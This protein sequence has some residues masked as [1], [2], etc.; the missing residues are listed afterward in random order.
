MHARTVRGRLRLN[1][2][3]ERDA[4]SAPTH[5]HSRLQSAS[6]PRL[7]RLL[8]HQSAAGRRCCCSNRS[9]SLQY[10]HLTLPAYSFFSASAPSLVF[11]RRGGW[12]LGPL[13]GALPAAHHRSRLKGLS[14][15]L[16]CLPISSFRRSPLSAA[17]SPARRSPLSADLLLLLNPSPPH[18]CPS[19][20]P[21][22]P[23][24]YDPKPS[25]L[26]W[27]P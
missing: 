10:V 19:F 9:L 1:C 4:R 17:V 22:G 6:A 25:D 18:N 11:I 23:L 21:R 12:R 2:E 7:P 20:G 16:P 26:H 15:D 13:H 5:S 27:K 3:R 14:A 24:L 8:A